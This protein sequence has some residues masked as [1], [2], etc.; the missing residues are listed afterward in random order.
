[1]NFENMSELK[2]PFGYY[3]LVT[4]TALICSALHWRLPENGCREASARADAAG[5]PTAA[6]NVAA[7]LLIRTTGGS[8]D[9]NT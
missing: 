2:S 3:G 4:T 5:R 1:M 9:R 8:G 7:A 6:F